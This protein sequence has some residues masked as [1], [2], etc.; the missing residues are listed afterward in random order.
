MGIL[1]LKSTLMKTYSWMYV[2][3]FY[4]T[5]YSC[6][7]EI[8]NLSGDSENAS[9][10]MK[11]SEFQNDIL[12]LA[13]SDAQTAAAQYCQLIEESI[14][15]AKLNSDEELVN[16]VT[17]KSMFEKNLDLSYKDNPERLD[18]VFSLIEPC[19]KK[20]IEFKKN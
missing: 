8:K 7:T 5:L 14:E 2:I 18:S 16:I 4:S 1:K 6:K 17:T 12:N 3:V 19:L 13:F 11:T 15:A 10:L 9:Y 20:E